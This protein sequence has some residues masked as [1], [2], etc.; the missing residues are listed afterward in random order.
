[1]WWKKRRIY[2]DYASATPVS[3]AARSATLKTMDVFGN[4][5]SIHADGVI[6]KK[7]LQDSRERIAQSLACK[8]R[9]VVFVSGGTE[10]NNL[11]ILGFARRL[12]ATTRTLKE[13]HWVVSAIEHPSVLE[14]FAEVERL[15]GSVSYVEPDPQSL[16]RAETLEK[17]LKP[18]TVF[19]SIGW[20]NHEIGT[21]QKISELS[22]VIH[23]HEKKYGSIVLFH[24]DAG[25][26][27]LFKS[28]HVHTLGVDLFSLDS[29]K[30]YGPRG[31]GVLFISERA[32]LASTLFGGR[33]ERGL[34]PGTENIALAAGFA[35]AIEE[36]VSERT[37]EKKLLKE[38]RSDLTKK[39]ATVSDIILNGDSERT[40]PN[41]INISIK[42]VDTEYLTLALDRDGISVATKSACREGEESRSPVIDALLKAS[43][44]TQSWRSENTL[45]ISMGKGTKAGDIEIAFLC[46][47]KNILLLRQKKMV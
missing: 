18:E 35:A 45:R 41:L 39:I 37:E 38:I 17:V 25:Q 32:E 29:G 9:E 23:V 44:S 6:A 19:V 5:G 21:V 2:L 4:P 36:L 33:Q 46:L 40:L 20:A 13:T 26:A 42:N 28:P 30:L 16:I 10:A 1:M 22:R 47:K 24:T 7:S 43:H 14:C 11:A 12:E 27:P 3:A 8:P 34:R 15:G 31:V